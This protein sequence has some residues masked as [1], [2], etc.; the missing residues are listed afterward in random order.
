MHRNFA[1]RAFRKRPKHGARIS[2]CL[3]L[4]KPALLQYNKH[5]LHVHRVVVQIDVSLKDCAVFR[6]PRVQCLQEL[7]VG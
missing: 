2:Y 4:P 6:N 5:Q 7:E 1:A 3:I